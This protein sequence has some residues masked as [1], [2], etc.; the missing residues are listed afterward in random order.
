MHWKVLFHSA[1]QIP[2]IQ[3]CYLSRY[4]FCIHK[5]HIFQYHSTAKSSCENNPKHNFN[6]E[7]YWKQFCKETSSFWSFM[8]KNCKKTC[9]LCAGTYR[10]ILLDKTLVHCTAQEVRG[11][12]NKGVALRTKNQVVLCDTFTSDSWQLSGV[13]LPSPVSLLSLVTSWHRNNRLT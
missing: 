1:F 3:H 7:Q 13:Q 11:K 4:V 10:L 9:G 6:C 5:K 8:K 2:G 12:E